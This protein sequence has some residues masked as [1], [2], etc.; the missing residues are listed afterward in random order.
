MTKICVY[1]Q[2]HQ[3]YFLKSLNYLEPTLDIFDHEFSKQNIIKVAHRCYLPT[4]ELLI[5]LIHQFQ[6]EVKF[7]FSL[8]G[9]A[10]EQFQLY[11][12]EVID[13]FKELFAMGNVEV[14]AETYHH[15]LCS[16]YSPLHFLKEIESHQQLLKSL[17]SVQAKTF[18][19][20]ELIYN[21]SIGE[22]IS[23][24]GYQVMLTSGVQHPHC[25]LFKSDMNPDLLLMNKH[26]RLSDVI[27]YRF[28]Q[29]SSF[30]Q[31]LE[32]ESNQYSCINLFWDYEVF[33][34]HVDKHF[35]IY[36]FVQDFV[37]HVIQSKKYQFILPIES[38]DMHEF[39]RYDSSKTLSWADES[40]DLSAWADNHMQHM[41]ID[42]IYK[43][44]DVGD[45]KVH[46]QWKQLLTSDHFYYMYAKQ[47][48]DLLAHRAFSPY[49][50]PHDA[51]LNYIN[52][53]LHL[54]KD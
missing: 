35:G 36:K 9:T 33:G 34:E 30:F 17:F 22:Q 47:G 44:G 16:I 29:S 23:K 3:P 20:T 43:F 21:P 12:P 42:E 24:L 14:L 41:A 27:A 28:H 46:K 15:S 38:R 54:F 8:T 6:G 48:P 32:H 4:T 53:I 39:E 1:F 11:S 25:A 18:R 26:R 5:K 31:M 49:R 2:V 50:S 52:A 37:R 45:E 10:L 51:F 13:G 40:Q 7:A 19:N